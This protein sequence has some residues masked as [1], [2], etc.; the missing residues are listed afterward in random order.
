MKKIE[1]LAPAGNM[2]SL[3]AAINAG[4]DAVYLSGKKYG[5]RAF[6]AN[7]SSEELIEA[8]KYAHLYDVKIYVTINT[9][10]YENEMDDF[11]NYVEFLYSINVDAVIMQDLGAMD[12]VRQKFPNLEIHAST[13]MNIH[14]LESVKLL[15]KLN[16][17]RA[18][19]S[20][21][22]SIDDINHIKN[23]SNIELEIFVQGA[24][25]VSFSGQCLMSS[26]IGGRSGN[27][28]TCA[29]CCRMK[30][31]LVKNFKT[32]D[33][34]YLLSTKDLCALN[35]I[36]K[37]IDIGVD[38]LKIEGR[39]KRKEYIYFAVSL[40]RKAIDSYYNT[41]KIDITSKDIY[42]LK[43]IFNRKFTKGFL[44]NENNNNFIN[45]ERPNHQGVEI[46][47]VINIK[48]NSFLLKLSDNL[49]INDGI[50][51]I[52]DDIGFTVTEMFIDSKRVKSAKKGDIVK[53]NYKINSLSKVVK[54]TDYMQL[55]EIQE[56]IKIDRK[57]PL[58]I[59]VNAKYN[60]KLEIIA[61][62]KE[63]S[64][65]LSSDYIIEK[66]TKVA[67]NINDIKN[68]IDRLNDT[69]YYLNNI[70]V[71][72]DDNIFIPVSVINN[73]RRD[74][75]ELLNK[76]RLER[77]K[78]IYGE[79]NTSVKDYPY[80]KDVCILVD[81]DDIDNLK[82]KYDEIY[83][84]KNTNDTTLKLNRIII[85]HD[86]IEKRVLV[87]ELGSINK[88]KSVVTDTY[89][90]VVNS[91]TVAFLHS[92]NVD[93]IT[94][95]YELDFNQIKDIIDS[96]HKRYNK[97]PNLEVIVSGYEEAMVCKY[98]LYGDYLKDR[99]NNLFKIKIRDDYMYIYN[100]KKRNLQ[101]DYYKIG[102]NSIR[103]NRELDYEDN[104]I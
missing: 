21:E 56:K 43:K 92:L 96:Y 95:S 86:D 49:N 31:D 38:S 88:Y 33:R 6:A 100:Y 36:D 52:N 30:Y 82:D 83:N 42:N 54:T 7:F 34:G 46:G 72:I 29:Q 2:E 11:I 32:I 71:N 61:K 74:I 23:N 98:K 73:L 59:I 17:K 75:I 18:V 27:R 44:F 103:Y 13:Q 45:K 60:K 68:K 10:I 14:S 77:N 62:Y 15:E 101:D 3:I 67:T 40:Y 93:K 12:L 63:Y 78:I 35:N 89:L 47:K 24:L 4:A 20:R 28:G 41:G 79:Y 90:N 39:M 51:I 99:F 70:I 19:L 66:S 80:K 76:K 91:Y 53:I 65:S 64:V 57:L 1:L 102:V 87:S 16:I 50:R 55:K 37:L 85:N 81:T 8:V 97:H 22:L 5:A 26:L 104:V 69:V 94:L 25:C 48:N 58:D 84:F 9:L